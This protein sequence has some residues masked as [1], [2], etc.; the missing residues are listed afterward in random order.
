M[1]PLTN[2]LKFLGEGFLYL[3][4][5]ENIIIKFYYLM[6]DVEEGLTI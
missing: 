5:T 2:T 4:A 6:I 1:F 3:I